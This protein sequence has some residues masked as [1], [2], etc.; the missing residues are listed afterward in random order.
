MLIVHVR[1]IYLV[2]KVAETVGRL[3]SLSGE[4]LQDY[5]FTSANVARARLSCRRR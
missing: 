1:S 3:V 4:R 2:D 5:V